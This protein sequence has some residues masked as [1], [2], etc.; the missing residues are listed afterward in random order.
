MNGVD[1]CGCSGMTTRAEEFPA[2]EP[3]DG[4]LG[5][6]F[7]DADVFG[8]VLIADLDGFAGAGVLGGEPE[9]DE[10]GG[11]AAVVAYEVA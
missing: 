6:A 3:G 8:E 5:G 10:E 2:E 11:G 1:G 7:R 4:R 9:I